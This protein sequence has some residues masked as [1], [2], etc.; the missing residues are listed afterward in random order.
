MQFKLSPREKKL[1]ALLAV[2]IGS[3]LWYQV[4]WENLWPRYQ[5]LKKDHEHFLVI[6]LDLAHQ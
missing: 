6:D 5:E 3:Y 1:L 4:F 2:V